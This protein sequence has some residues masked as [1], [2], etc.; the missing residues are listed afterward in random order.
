M[1]RRDFFRSQERDVTIRQVVGK[2]TRDAQEVYLESSRALVAFGGASISA[3]A[4]SL[5]DGIIRVFLR[6]VPGVLQVGDLLAVAKT[7]ALK[8]FNYTITAIDDTVT[9]ENARR[10]KVRIEAKRRS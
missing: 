5:P 2:D 3:G 4:E 1:G 10:Y 6:S 8:E 9:G 7:R